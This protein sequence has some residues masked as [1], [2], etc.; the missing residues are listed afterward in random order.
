MHL[1]DAGS[2]IRNADK[3]S[4]DYESKPSAGS[5]KQN[6]TLP[7]P[8][9]L[10]ASN[11][12]R[13]ARVRSNRTVEAYLIDI[14]AVNGYL[15]R[16]M[17]TPVRVSDT[18]SEGQM[19]GPD[20]GVCIEVGGEGCRKWYTSTVV[21]KDSTNGFYCEACRSAKPV[22]YVDRVNRGDFQVTHAQTDQT[23]ADGLTEGL[24]AQGHGG[25]ADINRAL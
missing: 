6:M 12:K 2:F 16:L 1:T 23:A 25:I 9:T 24:N 11:V 8:P 21:S 3:E 4:I 5:G 18:L 7:Q 14:D 20:R 13:D 10:P 15:R 22:R 19:P 17:P